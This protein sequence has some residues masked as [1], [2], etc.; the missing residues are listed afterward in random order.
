MGGTGGPGVDYFDIGKDYYI[1]ELEPKRDGFKVEGWS[2]FQFDERVNCVAKDKLDWEE[3]DNK[4]YLFAVWSLKTSNSSKKKLQ[5]LYGKDA[6]PDY[7]FEYEYVSPTW[8]RINDYCYFVIKTRNTGTSPNDRH[9]VSDYMILEY[10][11]GMWY[12]MT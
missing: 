3:A 5:T 2:Y 8:E 1:S 4:V 12:L 9:M 10:R 7:M 11:F 6:M